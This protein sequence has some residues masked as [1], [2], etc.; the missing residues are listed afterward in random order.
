MSRADD[1]AGH[2]RR[3][4]ELLGDTEPVGTRDWMARWHL[5]KAQA[6]EGLARLEQRTEVEPAGLCEAEYRVTFA[7]G[8]GP[9]GALD[10]EQGRMMLESRHGV[11]LQGRLVAEWV[12]IATRKPE[13]D[14]PRV[15]PRG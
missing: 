15:D 13:I 6:L 1:I 9:V 8:S 10:E 4:V 12:T 2:Y 3:V 7:H 11:A 14:T 5:A